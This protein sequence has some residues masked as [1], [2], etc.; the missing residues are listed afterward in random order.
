[1]KRLIIQII[2]VLAFNISYSQCED[3][4]EI[5]DISTNPDDPKNCEIDA[6]QPN[7]NN[8]LLNTAFDWAA[9]AG[10]A[11]D[12][13]SLNS[14]AGWDNTPGSGFYSVG[15]FLMQ[16]PFSYGYLFDP[17]K[18]L[19]EHDWHWEDGWELMFLNTGRYPNGQEIQVSNDIWGPQGLPHN[20]APYFMLYNKYTG[21]LRVFSNLYAP[22][23]TWDDVKLT[24]G[25][26]NK[27]SDDI[28]SGVFRHVENYDTPLDQKTRGKAISTYHKDESNS[29][30]K[31]FVSE[32]QLG[33]DACVCDNPSSLFDVTLS[34]IESFDV[35][36][37]GRSI[38]TELPLEDANGNPTYTDFLN[39]NSVT[40]VNNSGTNGAFIY[41]SLDG[42]LG[43]Y[44][45]ELEKY[46][47]DL[48]DY[49]S[50]GN[51]ALRSLM[52]LGKTGLNSGLTGLVPS[53]ILKGLS[54]NAV[55]VI[56]KNFDKK[57]YE[58]AKQWYKDANSPSGTTTWLT[59]SSSSKPDGQEAYEQMKKDAKSYSNELSKT[60]KGGVGALSDAVFA[61]FNTNQEAP[62][63]PSMPTASFTEM[64]ISGTIEDT[65]NVDISDLYTPGS[66]K[67]NGSV[68]QPLKIPVYNQPVGLFAM[69]ETPEVSFY[70][71]TYVTGKAGNFSSYF[72]TQNYIKL[73]SPLRYRF[74]HAV[75]FNFDKNELHG[76][77]QITY[78]VP[79]NFIE[80][81]EFGI[82]GSSNLKLLK[83]AVDP[84]TDKI[85]ATF[86]SDWIP[87]D[88]LGE[89]LVGGTWKHQ[90][91]SQGAQ[92]NNL[93][94]GGRI[95]KSITF[96]VMADMYFV[97][98][99]YNGTQKNTT[100][101]FTYLLYD[102]D[103]AVDF[104][105]TN[106]EY[107]SNSDLQNFVKYRVGELE[108]SGMIRPSMT[109]NSDYVPEVIGNII[110]VRAQSVKIVGGIAVESGYTAI[111]EAYDGI[112]I[113]ET[114]EV[115]EGISLIIKD[116]FYNFQP[117][118][119][120]GDTELKIF[121]K[122]TT[123]K[124]KSNQLSEP[125]MKQIDEEKE[126]ERLEALEKQ[127]N[128]KLN[129]KLYPNPT[130]DEF[131][132]DFDHVVSAIS[133]VIVDVNGKQVFSQFFEGDHTH[134]SLDASSLEAG[135][136]T[137]EIGTERGQVGQEKLIKF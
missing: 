18:T 105:A 67:F 22:I 68:A 56:N 76:M 9:N 129:L 64:T 33:Y 62:V 137:V 23:G 88:L 80:F 135:V 99:G 5:R 39:M 85:Y 12:A 112:E 43:N 72:E 47:T 118:D 55:R 48:A 29:S 66:F 106:G 119:E 102:A 81:K 92:P 111:I 42:M 2:A 70:K 116:N 24:I 59:A 114:A 90:S 63:K 110:Y 69:L 132:I 4:N 97:S 130:M 113:D 3:C 136:Y 94:N 86:T 35:K 134:I 109:I 21:K 61:S 44:N 40:D 133:V 13:I 89:Y 32:V 121:C 95:L 128:R 36:L 7:A 127:K 16:S 83:T 49:N 45:S 79:E 60:L 91:N 125:A 8:P 46:K 15:S 1:M 58:S 19:N 101:V 27:N 126:K 82:Y 123:K 98:Q 108:L 77:Y 93:S 120:V 73:K 6:W 84:N 31:W 14:N 65:D 54:T 100:Q 25:Y 30:N 78:E 41:K 51:V 37:T 131:K 57:N 28:V 38:T 75:D 124:Y 52:D 117:F 74:N 122:G 107:I 50:L 96:K 53:Y 17:N 11:F 26:H 10:G 71:R 34:G 87:F 115:N 20:N 104:I 103:N